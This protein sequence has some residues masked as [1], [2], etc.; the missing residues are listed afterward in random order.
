MTKQNFIEEAI[1]EFLADAIEKYSTDRDAI[2][3]LAECITD[4][5]G[6]TT[7][8]E[9]ARATEIVRVWRIM[10]PRA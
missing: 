2:G 6:E 8:A 10:N 7:E 4:V 1:L 5:D 3:A 9:T